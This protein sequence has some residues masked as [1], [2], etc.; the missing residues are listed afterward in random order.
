V[1]NLHEECGDAEFYIEAGWQVV[2][3]ITNRIGAR[4]YR[5]GKGNSVLG[6]VLPDLVISSGK[7][8]DLAKKAWVYNK[9]IVAEDFI[10]A[11]ALIEQ[12][13][14]D[15]YACRGVERDVVLRMNMEKL[16]LRYPSGYTDAAAQARADKAGE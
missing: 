9:P 16:A 7:Y 14:D 5:G 4:P 2:E 12:D 6:Y 8:L 10:E 15:F 13:L 1:W 11:L 3:A